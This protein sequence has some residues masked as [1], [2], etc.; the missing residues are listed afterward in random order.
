MDGSASHK[1]DFAHERNDVAVIQVLIILSQSWIFLFSSEVDSN[2]FEHKASY[3]A[4]NA[5]L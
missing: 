1:K 2:L 3:K 5:G 4:Q